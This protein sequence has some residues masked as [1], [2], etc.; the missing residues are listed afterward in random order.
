M[1]LSTQYLGLELRN[2]LVVGA[3]PLVT[4]PEDAR[5]LE[6]AGAAALVLHSLFEEEILA[7][8]GAHLAAEAHMDSFAEALSYL[9][10][11]GHPGP[12][13][14]LDLV[15]RVKSAVGI[16]VIG[17]LNGFTPGGWTSHARRI[18]EA[19]A[20]ALEL[21]VH[22]VASDP[23]VN[24][25]E[26]VMQTV[27]TVREV[28]SAVTIPVAVKLSPCFSS[29]PHM[30]TR[31]REVGASGL[32]VFNRFYQPDL[33][34]EELEV[35]PKLRLSTSEE[36]PERLRLISLLHG[37]VELSLAATGGV[38]TAVDV[39]KA[40]MAGADV[41]QMVSAL[42]LHGPEHLARTLSALEFWMEDHGYESLEQMKGCLSL[43]K[44]PNPQA[45]VRANY[46]QVLD[47]WKG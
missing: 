37:R 9:P 25:H 39:I 3:S 4:G 20:D 43:A 7:E 18:Q 14:Y 29:F 47:S 38:H 35:V 31:I 27:E 19:G 28:C 22:F 32:V 8:V 2:P 16:P 45:I 17:S 34:I 21:N 1:D 6:E 30:A 26:V 10:G 24:G 12:G 36:L 46:M 5:A 40:V 13:P 42:L 33:D 44:A 41:T 23:T 11:S 15:A